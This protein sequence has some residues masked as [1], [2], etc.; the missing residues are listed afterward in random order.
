MTTTETRWWW[1]RHAPVQGPNL[2]IY[3]QRDLDADVSNGAL[4]TALAAYLPAN[5]VLVSS[6]LARTTQ[7]A[8]AIGAAGLDLPEPILEPALREQH[9]GDWQ[10]LRRDE[11]R[12]SRGPAHAPFW[13]APASERAPNGES[14]LDLLARVAPAIERLTA[15]HAGRDIICTAH[16]GTI[17]AAL[18]HTL[19]IDPESALAFATDNC[20]VT[21]ID[22]TATGGAGLWRVVTVNRNPL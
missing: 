19:G 17:R 21:R 2:H 15:E 22:H 20:A 10:G 4:F 18:A 9:L 16:G 5:S 13:L 3:G 6:D 1:I 12:D 8:A 11:F 7:T 14:F